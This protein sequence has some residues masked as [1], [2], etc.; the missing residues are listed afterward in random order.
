MGWAAWAPPKTSSFFDRQPLQQFHQGPRAA[1]TASRAR[2]GLGGAGEADDLGGIPKMDF[3]LEKI[4]LK[5][6]IWGYPYFRKQPYIYI[7]LFVYLFI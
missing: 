4:A 1:P 3:F 2:A 6:M 5:L 7:Y